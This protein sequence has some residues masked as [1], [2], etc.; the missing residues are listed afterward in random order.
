MELTSPATAITATAITAIIGTTTMVTWRQ[1]SA[2]TTTAFL[3]RTLAILSFATACT[4]ALMLPLNTTQ[5]WFGSW[6][7]LLKSSEPVEQATT[8]TSG[9]SKPAETKPSPLETPSPRP[10]PQR[11]SVNTADVGKTATLKPTAWGGY[12]ETR[13]P[14]PV[15]GHEDNAWIW[16][17]PSYRETVAAGQTPQSYPVIYVMHGFPGGPSAYFD[18]MK[19]DQAMQSAVTGNKMRESIMVFPTWSAGNVDTECTDGAGTT[20]K[21]ETWLSQDVTAWVHQN[22][23]SIPQAEST[24]TLGYSAGGYCSI[25]LSLL[26]PQKFGAAMGFGA[27][28]APSFE[29]NVLFSPDSPQGQRYDL[30]KLVDN[31]P[32]KT[33]IWLYAAQNDRLSYKPSEKLVKSAKPPLIAALATTERGGHR[34]DVWAQ[35]LPGAYTWLGTQLSG[36]QPVTKR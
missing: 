9:K 4:V 35:Q 14:G 1:L 8:I 25:M 28:T 2:N 30:Q 6:E 12:F 7:D 20:P 23:R 10:T 11:L 22:L 34:V 29:R 27:Y 18:V 31:A 16:L 19:V 32:P 21:V 33:A 24:A 15:S 17:P 13:I 26:H 3:G 5:G 36:F